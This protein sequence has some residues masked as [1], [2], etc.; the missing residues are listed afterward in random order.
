MRASLALIRASRSRGKTPRRVT[1]V[2]DPVLTTSPPW[3]SPCLF[4][5]QRLAARRFHQRAQPFGKSRCVRKQTCCPISNRP[6]GSTFDTEHALT[7]A[8]IHIATDRSFPVTRHRQ[9]SNQYVGRPSRSAAPHRLDQPPSR[10]Q[11]LPRSDGHVVRIGTPAAGHGCRRCTAFPPPRRH[12]S[13]AL[14]IRR[15]L[16]A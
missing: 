3:S 4:A 15:G 12:H 11:G 1:W 7:C 2:E 16:D 6:F 10:W 9:D 13:E 14:R 8:N 5:R